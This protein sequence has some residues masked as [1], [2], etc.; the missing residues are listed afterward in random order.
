[1]DAAL[2][3]L[4]LAL[5]DLQRLPDGRARR[6]RRPAARGIDPDDPQQAA[7][8]ALRRVPRALPAH[9]PR[10]T[11]VH[12]PASCTCPDCGAA[13]RKLGEDVSELLDFVP[14]YFKVIRACAAQALLR[15]LRAGDPAAGA[16]AADRA[17]HAGPGLLA[18]V[19]VA[20][21]A[22][23]CP[24]YR[25]QGIYR[26]AGVEL[27]R[28]TLADWVGGASG[29]LEPLVDA[30]GRYVLAAGEGARRRH[31]GAGAGSRARQD[32]DRAAVDLR[33]R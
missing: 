29:L 20:K 32:Q 4:Q 13:M 1:M 17:R 10:E 7:S 33:A 23:H 21:Y 30:L 22:D 14:G 6:P 5:D 11:I 28:A 18:Q 16:L 24:L 12:A 2:L 3:Q 8:D 31:P 9:L 25:Q 26:R 27:D 15:P 19:I